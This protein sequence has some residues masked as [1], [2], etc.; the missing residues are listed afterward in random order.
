MVFHITNIDMAPAVGLTFMTTGGAWYHIK[1]T[2]SMFQLLLS[3]Y[4]NRR[5]MVFQRI[6]K[7]HGLAWLP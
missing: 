6:K 1:L 4:D 2:E 7:K 5:G 3:S